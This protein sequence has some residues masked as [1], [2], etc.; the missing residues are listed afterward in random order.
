MQI[1][2]LTNIVKCVV[3]IVCIASGS[4]GEINVLMFFSWKSVMLVLDLDI[5]FIIR[6]FTPCLTHFFADIY[7]LSAR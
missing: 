7:K 2:L 1:I 3:G 6:I 4:A 5:T